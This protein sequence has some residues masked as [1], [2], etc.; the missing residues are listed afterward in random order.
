MGTKTFARRLSAAPLLGSALLLALALLAGCAAEPPPPPVPV[1]GTPGD[2]RALTGEWEGEY[3]SAETGRNGMISFR[4]AAGA[5][6]AYGDVLMFPS[7]GKQTGDEKTT[8]SALTGVQRPK[9]LSIKFVRV[10]GGEISGTLEIYRDPRCD[11]D[12]RTTF[13][14]QIH[15]DRV[16]GAFVTRHL[17][18]EKERRGFWNIVRKK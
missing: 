13:T 10:E 3:R 6:T 8:V 9:W 4:L 12:V 11:C 15:G 2:M 18:E 16:S 5:D 17:A 14:G 1:T 7:V